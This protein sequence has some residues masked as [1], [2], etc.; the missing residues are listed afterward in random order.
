MDVTTVKSVR[1]DMSADD[2][3]ILRRV[4]DTAILPA[5][6]T[7]GEELRKR[8]ADRLTA[9]LYYPGNLRENR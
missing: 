6:D 7:Q 5:Y 1:L 9:Q 2:A 3:V 8:L 4:L